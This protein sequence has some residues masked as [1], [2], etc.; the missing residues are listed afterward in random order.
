MVKPLGVS[1]RYCQSHFP[2]FSS[3]ASTTSDWAATSTL[4]PATTGWVASSSLASYCH[5]RLPVFA[6]S[7]ESV[8]S[9]QAAYTTPPWT[10]GPDS[11]GPRVVNVH[12]T[13][14]PSPTDRSLPSRV[15][16]ISRLVSGSSAGVP[17]SRGPYSRNWSGTSFVHQS[18]EYTNRR[19]AGSAETPMS[20]T[21]GARRQP[22]ADHTAASAASVPRALPR[23]WA[24]PRVGLQRRRL[25]DGHA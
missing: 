3:T 21:S 4:P 15:P 18:T 25:R 20:F 9:A 7:A 22:A 2:V 16:T 13:C 23:I 14:P 24:G 19:T 12:A 6:V 11:K 10:V 1:R 8:P 5:R 17:S